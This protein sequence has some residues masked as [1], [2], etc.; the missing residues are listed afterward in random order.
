MMTT[1]QTTSVLAGCLIALTA[2]YPAASRAQ[3]DTWRQVGLF[4]SDSR[5]LSVGD[6]AVR[7]VSLPDLNVL[8]LSGK[9]REDSVK[10]ERAFPDWD[11]RSDLVVYYSLTPDG[12]TQDSFFYELG[13][14]FEALPGDT[15]A[16]Q[17]PVFDFGG[18]RRTDI[19]AAV[20]TAIGSPRDVLVAASLKGDADANPEWVV[21]SAVEWDKDRQGATLT[22][23]FVQL[24]EGEW[25]IARTF[26]VKEYV[27]CGPLEVRDVTGDGQ[28]DV[29]FRGFHQT[30]GHYWIDARVFSTHRDMPAV[31]LPRKFNPGIA[32]GPTRTQ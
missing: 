26:D 23:Q 20:R 5:N 1:Q 31:F 3:S 25:K 4:R 19:P 9:Y 32:A 2:A 15:V 13:R 30:L 29:V 18:E 27:R 17:V 11:R 21:G 10:V 12:V 8:G 6:S 24:T 22:F 16:M 14:D 7:V 28:A